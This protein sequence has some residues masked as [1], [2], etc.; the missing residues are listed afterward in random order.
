[1]RTSYL[2]SRDSGGNSLRAAKATGCCARLGEAAIATVASW[3]PDI[4]A[5]AAQQT[6]NQK[7]LDLLPAPLQWWA[8]ESDDA[9]L[10][11]APRVSIHM[12]VLWVGN[13][14]CVLG[15]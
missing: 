1:M 11:R 10:L 5:I 2:R 7:R 8:I 9:G 6:A 14:V 13:D 12:C 4:A 15:V 3:L